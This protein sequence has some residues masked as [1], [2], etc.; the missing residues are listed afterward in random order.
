MFKESF[1]IQK[2]RNCDILLQYGGA[3]WN[4][5]EDSRLAWAVAFCPPHKAR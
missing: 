4:V 2:R 5:R 1:E 3:N